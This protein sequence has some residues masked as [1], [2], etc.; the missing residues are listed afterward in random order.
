V[1]Y[2]RQ[3]LVVGV[4]QD[5]HVRELWRSDARDGIVE[6]SFE[7][8]RKIHE[9]RKVQGFQHRIGFQQKAVSA[10]KLG[11]RYGFQSGVFLVVLW[12]MADVEVPR[13]C[14]ERR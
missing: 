2:F 14:L 4:D 5:P 8:T 1:V 10:G 13:N 6:N 3:F 12:T 9:L 11:Q 7:I